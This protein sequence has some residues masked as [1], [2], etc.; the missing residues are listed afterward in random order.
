[1][2]TT[3]R[4]PALAAPAPRDSASAS[5]VAIISD[6]PVPHP[7]MVRT[8]AAMMAREF[9]VLGRNLPS[10]FVRSV[11][12]P[13]LWVFV[14]TYV[15]PK[16]GAASIFE[17]GRFTRRPAAPPRPRSPPSCCRA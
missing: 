12:Q 1:M 17:A 11:V 7:A 13:L 9:R 15:L 3:S 10:T 4:A 2:T 14:F 5:A 6:A 16:I 8:F